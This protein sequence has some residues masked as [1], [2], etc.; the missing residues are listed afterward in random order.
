MISKKKKNAHGFFGGNS[1]E[2]AAINN[3]GR[4]NIVQFKTVLIKADLFLIK[5]RKIKRI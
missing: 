1:I 3:F 5:V 2:Y 4:T